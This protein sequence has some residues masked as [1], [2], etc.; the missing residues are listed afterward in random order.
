M[1]EAF[2]TFDQYAV[3]HYE[4]Q[5]ADNSMTDILARFAD[6]VDVPAGRAVI[7][8]ANKG[9][10]LPTGTEVANGI[11]LRLYARDNVA[12]DNPVPTYADGEEFSM[13]RV[14]RVWVKTLAATTA[15]DSVYVVPSTGELTNDPA[16]GTNIQLPNAVF[17]TDADA[18]ALALV[19]MNGAD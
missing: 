6:G 2:G 7:D 14:G 17:K 19:Q 13:L 18:D 5:L 15:G 4:G 3:G 11:A 9:A 16:G 12:G 1:A 10:D 8:T